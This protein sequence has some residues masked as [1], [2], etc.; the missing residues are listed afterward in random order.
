MLTMQ[1]I[2]KVF[3]VGQVLTHALRS[4]DLSVRS[5]DFLAITGPSGSGKSTLLNVLGLL[6]GSSSGHYQIDGVDVR[7]LGDSALSA[8]RNEKIGFVFQA[9]N[10][11]PDLNVQ[12]NVEVPLRYRGM[13]TAERRERVAAALAKVGLGSRMSHFPGELSGGQQQRVAIA[14]AFAGGP[15]LLLA[16][17]PTGNLDTE[18]AE[19]VMNILVGL[20]A[21]GMTIIMVTHDKDLAARAG[22]TI[23][24]V[25]G[26]IV[27]VTV[28]QETVPA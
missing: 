22:R 28:P 9:F 3:Q 27:E 23:S 26:Q 11:I 14:R 24:I 20:N 17:E 4:I 13:P 1:G 6:E 25:D 19:A 2:S 7:G 10:L 12:A 15:A 8:L 21:E 5:G 16:D 18:M